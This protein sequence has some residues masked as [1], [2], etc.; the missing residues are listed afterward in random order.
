PW[1]A[2][3]TVQVLPSSQGTVL[4]AC[5]QPT[6]GSQ[7][8]SVQ[9]LPSLQS[10][11]GP[12]TQVPATQVS[13]VV[14]ALPSSQG[15]TL[16]TF[17]QTPAVQLSSVEGLPP[18]PRGRV[19]PERGW[20]VWA[21]RQ[22]GPWAQGAVWCGCRRRRAGARLS[23]VQGLPSSQLVALPPRQKP[24]RQASPVVQALPSVQV[25]PS[26]SVEPAQM[27][28]WQLS[29]TVQLLPSSQLP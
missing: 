16:G 20:E 28:F 9:R 6:A 24:L 19:P 7:A 29:E 3:F 8:S 25:L 5:V 1:Q 18:L 21:V 22:A 26:V 23:S 2:S 14:Q 27:P 17:R 12:P 11:A 4:F 13:P 10:G 15:P